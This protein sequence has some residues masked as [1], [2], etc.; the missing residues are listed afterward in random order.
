MA[1]TTTVE[2]TIPA[3]IDRVFDVISDHAGYSRF[4]GIQYSELVREGD[5][6]RN[7]VG[8]VRRIRSR[9]LRFEEK[10]TLFERPTRMDYLITT[11]NAPMRHLGGSMKLTE[12]DGGTH[13]EW[14][15]TLEPTL[16]LVGAAFGAFT[17]RLILRGFGRVLEEVERLATAPEP[18]A[19]PVA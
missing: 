13:I 4:P 18:V 19:A 17:R 14:S 7:G 2:R 10:I 1:Y 8:A 15:T 11:V 9:P 16:P 6:E 3:P 5:S 12:R